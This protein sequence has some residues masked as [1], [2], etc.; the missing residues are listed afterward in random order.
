MYQNLQKRVWLLTIIF[1]PLKES[2]SV[3]DR[4]FF[5]T[6]L[7]ILSQFVLSTIELPKLTLSN[8]M[9]IFTILVVLVDQFYFYMHHQP[10]K[11]WLFEKSYLLSQF[12]FAFSYGF[13][14]TCILLRQVKS[15]KKM[16]ALS[17]NFTILISGS[18]ICIPLILLSALMRLAST[19]AAILYR[20]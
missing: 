20:A 3:S 11:S 14:I 5:A 16:V 13:K 7:L 8:L 2:H 6:L 15:F 9:L 17:G 12:I 19:S 18:P 10:I 1:V 4:D